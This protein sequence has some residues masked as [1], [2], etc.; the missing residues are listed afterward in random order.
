MEPVI[1]P[2]IEPF[3]MLQQSSL[4]QPQAGS[5]TPG[6]QTPDF[7]AH[8]NWTRLLAITRGLI[9]EAGYEMNARSQFPDGSV[10]F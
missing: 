7:L 1:P 3:S 10:M 9:R 4:A 2:M 8:L 6:G 5:A